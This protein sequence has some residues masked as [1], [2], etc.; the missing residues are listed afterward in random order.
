M[1][2][3]AKMR[4]PGEF[5]VVHHDVRSFAGDLSA[6]DLG[7]PTDERHRA[8]DGEFGISTAVADSSAEIDAF[9][10]LKRWV[11][12]RWNHGWSMDF[13]TVDDG[14]DILRAAAEGAQFCCG[15][16]ARVFADCAT[17]LGW[18]A[19]VIGIS[20][21]GCEFPRNHNVGNVGHA[22]AEIWS[23]DHEKWV[24]MDPDLNCFYARDGVPL[25]ALEIRNAWLDGEAGDVD[26]VL[27]EPGFV[28]PTGD[29][30]E[31]AK[32]L[33]PG[34]NDFT[35][36]T[37]RLIF[38]R[39]NRHRSMDYY[40][41]LRIAGWEWAD[42]RCLPTF[43]AHFHPSPQVRYTSNLDDLYPTLNMVR[44]SMA[45]AWEGDRA[46]LTV[47]SEHCMPFFSH[48]EARVD[49]GGWERCESEFE[50]PM[51]EGVNRLECRGVNVV[52]RAGIISRIDVAYARPRW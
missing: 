38:A 39:F 36:E 1:D 24:V 26:Q 35:E 23:N 14:L 52:G 30:I 29:T 5:C 25:S 28:L 42:H 3:Q 21:A 22:V 15:H 27:D 11:R 4:V 10:A 47:G 9:L 31:L 33:T 41:R 40:A 45:P 46:R 7:D 17:A 13:R 37:V 34:L 18:P 44:F 12:S 50:W 2:V 6:S 48:Y 16:Y 51:R 43:I 49:G 8:L 32:E 19:R 20:I